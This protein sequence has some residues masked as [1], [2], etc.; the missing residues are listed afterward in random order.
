MKLRSPSSLA[1]LWLPSLAAAA[2]EDATADRPPKDRHLM[3]GMSDFQPLTCNANL[4]ID[5]CDVAHGGLLLSALLD[6]HAAAWSSSA[7]LFADATA[8]TTNGNGTEAPP[9]VV[10]PCGRCAVAD[11]ASSPDRTLVAPHGIDVHGM[12][13]LP[14]QGASS[15][16]LEAAHVIVQGTLKLD[17]PS[18][19]G[20]VTIKLVGPDEN[21]YLTPHPENAMACANYENGAC[22]LGK[23]P[24]AVAGGTLDVRG[25]PD[26]TTDCPA[27][28]T[29]Q[30]IEAV[31]SSEGFVRREGESYDASLGSVS[32]GTSVNY[33]DAGDAVI[34]ECSRLFFVVLQ[35]AMLREERKGSR[36]YVVSLFL[37]DNG[38]NEYDGRFCF[39]RA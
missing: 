24:V 28:V 1:L 30:K 18:A 8:T 39:A 11:F 34:C 20:R 17:P 12:L 3:E 26:A 33:F 10:V 19:N 7:G 36:Y 27:W 25:V 31:G 38:K 13:H 5:D 23:R 2:L 15:V 29:L 35:F 16:V 37:F 14:P 9:P 22:P 4:T 6:E 21:V 32:A